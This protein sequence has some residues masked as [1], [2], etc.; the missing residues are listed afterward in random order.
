MEAATPETLDG[1]D[2]TPGRTTHRGHARPNR[3]A[4][5]VYRASSAKTHTTAEFG[6]PQPQL[7][8]QIPQQGRLRIALER[9]LNT[10]DS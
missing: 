10:V 1:Y 7:V 8:A 9:L 2:F 4:A 5:E 6:S 3:L